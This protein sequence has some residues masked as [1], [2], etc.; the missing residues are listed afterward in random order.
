MRG[1]LPRRTC[2]PR[3]TAVLL[4]LFGPRRNRKVGEY[5]PGAGVIG[6]RQ[7]RRVRCWWRRLPDRC[8][9]WARSPPSRHQPRRVVRAQSSMGIDATRPMAGIPC[10]CGRDRGGRRIGAVAQLQHPV[11][12]CML[13]LHRQDELMGTSA[14]ARA[15]RSLSRTRGSSPGSPR[16]VRHSTRP[17]SAQTL[18]GCCAQRW[19]APLSPRSSR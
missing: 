18:S 17:C 3:S 1:V 13:V 11:A 5:R 15:A 12:C 6:D 14:F 16:R 8:T 2:I 10:C 4:E 19:T 7:A 9:R